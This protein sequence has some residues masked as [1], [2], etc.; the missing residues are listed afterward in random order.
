MLYLGCVCGGGL[1]FYLVAFGLIPLYKFIKKICEKLK[2]KCKCHT[3]AVNE[4]KRN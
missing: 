3:G 1:E 4:S 2:C